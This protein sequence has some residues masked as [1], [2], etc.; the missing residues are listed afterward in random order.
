[1]ITRPP[2]EIVG[3]IPV[4]IVSKFLTKAASSTIK[5]DNASDL[6]ASSEVGIAFIDEP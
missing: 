3:Y 2:V 6:P 1:M 5:S 4:Q